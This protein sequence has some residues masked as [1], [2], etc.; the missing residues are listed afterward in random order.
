MISGLSGAL[1]ARQ[2]HILC[3]LQGNKGLSFAIGRY[4]LQW[5]LCF[6]TLMPSVS[7]AV[8]GDGIGLA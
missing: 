6:A 1:Q 5:V 7:H 8:A 3:L 4:A 2:L